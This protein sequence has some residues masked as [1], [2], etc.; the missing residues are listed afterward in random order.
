MRHPVFAA[1]LVLFC[2]FS[3]ISI[4]AVTVDKAA[5]VKQRRRISEKTLMA[6]AALG[7]TGVM[8]IVMKL[9]RHKTRRP[10]FM[11][12]LPILFTVQAGLL[13]LSRFFFP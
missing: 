7:G 8:W 6:L 4:V 1:L 3:L 13:L 12:G 5:A 9:V 2:A 11:I 10:K